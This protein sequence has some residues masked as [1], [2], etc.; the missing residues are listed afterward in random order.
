MFRVKKVASSSDP[1]DPNLTFSDE[2]FWIAHRSRGNGGG[3]PEDVPRRWRD[4]QGE[5]RI[6]L[7]PIY[8]AYMKGYEAPVDGTLLANWVDSPLVDG[9]IRNGIRTVED[10]AH[11]P[12]DVVAAAGIGG[13]A[14][15]K[16]AQDHVK[17]GETT[18]SVAAD[19][20]VANAKIEELMA[21]VHA[22]QTGIVS[23]QEREALAPKPKRPYTRRTNPVE[24]TAAT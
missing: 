15:Q 2:L 9:L 8:E 17:K 13:I 18:K 6:A 22:L 12:H 20:A 21:Q 7:L 4:I 11:A 1:R 10:L 19:L 16:R 23:P 14:L 5:E 3:Q 24:A